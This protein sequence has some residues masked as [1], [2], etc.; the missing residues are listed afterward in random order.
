MPQRNARAAARSSKEQAV[1]PSISE[2]LSTLRAD[3]KRAWSSLEVYQL[4][5]EDGG[6]MSKKNLM[7]KIYMELEEEIIVLSSIGLP[8]ILMF[9]GHACSV[10]RIDKGDDDNLEVVRNI[11]KKIRHEVKSMELDRTKYNRRIDAD[12]AS[13]EFSPTLAFLISEIDP[14]LSFSELPA[15]LVGNIITN[16]IR[17]MPTTLNIALS[18]LLQQ[19][20]LI[21]KFYDYGVS[22]SY[23]EHLRFKFSAA[24]ACNTKYASGRPFT[25]P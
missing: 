21:K 16:I 2:V 1:H 20:H 23:D 15:I 22:C 4:F 25:P 13:E 11:A 19:K 7:A 10:I 12:V 17:K 6:K 24:V 8:N 5:Q 3:Q 14:A 9:K 18:I